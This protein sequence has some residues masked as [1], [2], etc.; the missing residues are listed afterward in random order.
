MA[1]KRKRSLTSG[2]GSALVAL[3]VLVLNP[4]SLMFINAQYAICKSESHMRKPEVYEPVGEALALY[5]QS[6]PLLQEIFGTG[7][8]Y[9]DTA[10]LPEN[11]SSFSIREDAAYVIMGG[12]FY[13][14]GYHLLSVSLNGGYAKPALKELR[15]AALEAKHTPDKTKAFGWVNGMRIFDPYDNF[16]IERLLQRPLPHRA[17]PVAADEKRISEIPERD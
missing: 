3:G 9:L 14:W 6:Y 4:F 1:T 5:C 2:T 7:P 11:L 17:S 13:H 8:V 15:A 10:W 12:G 16:D